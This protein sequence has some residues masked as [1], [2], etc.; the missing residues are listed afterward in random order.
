MPATPT[1]SDPKLRELREQ[2]MLNPHPEDVKDPLFLEDGFFDPHDLL[3]VKYEMLHRVWTDKS[4]VS[5][6]AAAFGVSRV[7]F[8]QVLKRFQEEGMA[9]L[10]PKLRGPKAAYKLTGEVMAFVEAALMSNATLRPPALVELVKA[11]FGISLHPR[12][13]ERALAKR[14]KKGLH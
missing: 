7:T 12:S 14:Q 3:Q 5:A 10:F 6:V 4:P 9:G 13:I 1:S 8:Y 2:G 11:Q